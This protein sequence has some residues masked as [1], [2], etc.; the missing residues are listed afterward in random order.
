MI[1][2]GI[3]PGLFTF[4]RLTTLFFSVLV[5]LS[6]GSNY[7][8]HFTLFRH[9]Y[10][11]HKFLHI[12]MT[13]SLVVSSVAIWD[14]DSTFPFCH[15]PIRAYALLAQR[16]EL[17][18]DYT[19][20]SIFPTSTA[21][22]VS[23]DPHAHNVSFLAYLPQLGA[24]LRLTHTQLNVF[25]VAGNGTTFTPYL[26]CILQFHSSRGLSDRP[27]L[28]KGCRREGPTTAPDRRIH[29]PPHWLFRNTWHL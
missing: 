14:P 27:V 17:L 23:I 25:A 9:W 29:F 11:A 15:H 5:A 13:R 20:L 3:T 28:G 8:R 4:A 2:R 10:C 6:S 18:F 12:S 7:V 24:R 21:E 26:A 16:L 1:S 19:S 22:P